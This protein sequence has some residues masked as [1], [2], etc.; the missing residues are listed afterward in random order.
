MPNTSGDIEQIAPAYGNLFTKRHGIPTLWR[1]ERFGQDDSASHSTTKSGAA[2]SMCSTGGVE[3]FLRRGKVY[4]VAP[5]ISYFVHSPG[6]G[7]FGYERTD[8]P[9]PVKN[10]SADQRKA[11]ALRPQHG[12]STLPGRSPSHYWRARY[13]AHHRTLFAAL[14][15]LAAGEFA[16][17]HCGA[18]R[19]GET[20]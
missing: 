7:R 16:A 15:S 13:V 12:E 5:D 11:A 1:I 9:N 20:R 18:P 3:R 14:S 2:I 17:A 10:C 4:F 8:D 19:D 6:S